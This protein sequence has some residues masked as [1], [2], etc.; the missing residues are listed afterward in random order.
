MAERTTID[1]PTTANAHLAALEARVRELEARDAERDRVERTLIAQRDVLQAVLDES[2]DVI[3]VKDH[4]GNFLLGNRTVATLYGTTPEAMVGKHDGDFSAT[5]EQADF[6]R[7]NVLAIMAS[8][9][10]EI[11]MEDSTDEKTGDTRNFKSIKK[12]FLGQDGKPQ[13]LVIAHDITDVRRAQARVADSEKRLQSVLAATGEGVWDWDL[14][15]NRLEHNQR[16]FDLLGYTEDDLSG[17]VED[18]HRCVLEEER[19]AVRQEIEA[20]LRGERPY[21]HEHGMRRRDGRVIRVLD[22]GDV[23]ERDAKGR[24]LRMVGSFADITREVEA[25]EVIRRSLAE[26]ETLLKE[27]HHRVKN[28]LQIIS[29]LLSL[30]A[31]ARAD[32]VAQPLLDSAA[33]VRSMALIHQ[34]LYNADD[35]GHVQFGDYARTLARDLVTSLAPAAR[36]DVE[37]EETPLTVDQAVPCGLI[38]NELLTNAFKHG[39][40]SDGALHVVVRV[41]HDANDLRFSVTDHG[42]GLPPDFHPRR[43]PGTGSLGMHLVTSLA[44]Q[45]RAKVEY[46]NTP[47]A[48]VTLRVPADGDT[49]APGPG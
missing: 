7:Q 31:N 18:F 32:D 10:T 38:L 2:P 35:L 40:G 30:Q 13:I 11:V 16:W 3:V 34:R 15:T 46:A 49:R 42:P 39:R 33:R 4:E 6:F 12:P 27:V 21:R 48:T 45:L 37:A 22:R 19:D 20:T 41:A 14:R 25:R 36:V 9:R 28:N 1:A 29:S 5:P 44:R 43:S 23:V 8:G 26:K 47:G 24:P 17:T